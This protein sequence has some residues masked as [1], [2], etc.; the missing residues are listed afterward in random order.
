MP[1]LIALHLLS[2]LSKGIAFREWKEYYL[3]KGWLFSRLLLSV[4]VNCK[5]LVIAAMVGLKSRNNTTIT[6]VN[7]RN[8]T[9][10]VINDATAANVPGISKPAPRT[11]TALWYRCNL[12]AKGISGG[13]PFITVLKAT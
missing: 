5:S 8:E 9:L 12:V 7:N 13:M 10:P 6:A 4:A 3:V 1:F 2:C 11:I